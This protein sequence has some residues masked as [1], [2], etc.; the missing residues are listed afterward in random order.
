[1]TLNRVGEPHERGGRERGG[2]EGE[3]KV[4]NKSDNFCNRRFRDK[5][6]PDNLHVN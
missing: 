4:S 5:I 3:K 6:P 1:M 2:R